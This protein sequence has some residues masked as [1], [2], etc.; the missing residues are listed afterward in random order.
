MPKP[1]R[2]SLTERLRREAGTLVDLADYAIRRWYDGSGGADPGDD[3]PLDNAAH[4]L[5]MAARRLRRIE[6]GRL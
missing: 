2:R 3:V 6:R 4:A 1:K 5:R